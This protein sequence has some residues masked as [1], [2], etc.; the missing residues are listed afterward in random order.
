MTV[1]IVLLSKM[2]F[3][4]RSRFSKGCS[5][6]YCG[7]NPSDLSGCAEADR[8]SCR[9]RIFSGGHLAYNVFFTLLPDTDD[10]NTKP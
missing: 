6:L 1:G 5:Q 8:C 9:C 7:Y 2:Q 10:I 4:T 3:E